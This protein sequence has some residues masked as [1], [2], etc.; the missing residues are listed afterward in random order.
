[1]TGLEQNLLFA[2]T[3]VIL[4]GTLIVFVV[5]YLRSTRRDRDERDDRDDR[6]D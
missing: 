6:V 2:A 4:A 3:T 5:Q 1:M